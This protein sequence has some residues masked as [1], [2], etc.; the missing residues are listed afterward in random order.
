MRH[1]KRC[2]GRIVWVALTLVGSALPG[3]VSH[4]EPQAARFGYV[5][6]VQVTVGLKGEA[7]WKPLT[8]QFEDNL[9]RYLAAMDDVAKS[10]FLSPVEV[11]ELKRLRANPTPTNAAKE[12]IARIEAKSLLIDEEY[13]RLAA[14]EKLTE[15]DQI[16][17]KE[18]AALREANSV[19][20]MKDMPRPSL[21]QLKKL[22]SQK[23]ERWQA[24]ILRVVR[25]VS[26]RHKLVFVV[27]RQ[28]VPSDEGV[29]LTSEVLRELKAS[30]TRRR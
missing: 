1:W 8:Q 28:D 23:L 29:D 21:T 6:L 17:I 22:E 15:A 4:A 7:E 26:Q 18:L 27:D 3:S 19:A 12:Q 2:S 24:R 16:R 9:R 14:L 11:E 25:K 10:R 13:Q 30:A 20:L 5:D